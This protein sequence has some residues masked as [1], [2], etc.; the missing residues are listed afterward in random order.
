MMK[1]TLILFI[2]AACAVIACVCEDNVHS[3]EK[4]NFFQFG[5]MIKRR[6]GRSALDYNGYGCWCGLGG[7]G[8]PKDGVDRCCRAHDYC[9]DR[10]IKSGCR[11]PVWNSYRYTLRW[12]IY[13]YR[14]GNDRC[15]LGGCRCDR[16]AAY[17]FARNTYHNKYKNWKGS[18]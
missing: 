18:C 17:C 12:G 13:C 15:E 1:T 14:G 10:L 4:R 5:R 16:T 7:K 2:L 8:T 9:Y 6:T 11:S 3:R